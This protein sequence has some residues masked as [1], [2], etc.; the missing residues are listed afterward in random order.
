MSSVTS[1]LKKEIR[2]K[3]Q[4]RKMKGS[5][6]FKPK[7]G[8][9]QMAAPV[10]VGSKISTSTSKSAESHGTTTTNIILPSTPLE[11]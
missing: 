5:R 10:F 4:R 6:V 11:M 9:L 8:R 1:V 2:R 7:N 3:M